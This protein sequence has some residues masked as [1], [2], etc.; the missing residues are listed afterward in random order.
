MSRLKKRKDFIRLSKTGRKKGMRHFMIQVAPR[1]L[2]DATNSEP[3]V[4]LTASRR[5]GGAVQRNRARRRLYSL[6]EQVIKLHARPDQD[7]VLI[8]RREILAASFGQLKIELERALDTL[9]LR[10]GASDNR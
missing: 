3:R 6:A 7:Y 10:R 8:A 1:P 5:V 4:G 2:D 9:D